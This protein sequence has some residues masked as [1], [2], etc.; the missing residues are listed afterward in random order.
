MVV[1]LLTL[2]FVSFP[3]IQFL[4]RNQRPA[5]KGRD[6]TEAKGGMWMSMFRL[7]LP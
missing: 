5:Q 3:P 7:N 1:S 4:V 2:D 6:P